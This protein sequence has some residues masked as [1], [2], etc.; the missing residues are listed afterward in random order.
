MRCASRS[1]LLAKNPERFGAVD[2]FD[3]AVASHFKTLAASNVFDMSAFERRFQDSSRLPSTLEK[4]EP[5]ESRAL[6]VRFISR[7][8]CGDPFRNTIKSLVFG[9]VGSR[10]I[11]SVAL[12]ADTLSDVNKVSGSKANV[13]TD[14]EA[15][16]SD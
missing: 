16:K 13:R 8:C 7:L 14:L 5:L 2:T 4:S 12:G 10:R 15:W 3:A 11:K 9:N 1:T 6:S